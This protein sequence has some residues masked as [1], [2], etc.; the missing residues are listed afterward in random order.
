[1]RG[2]LP[3]SARTHRSAATASHRVTGGVAAVAG[4][5]LPHRRIAVSEHMLREWPLRFLLAARAAYRRLP[6]LTAAYRR[7]PPLNTLQIKSIQKLLE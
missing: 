6:P 4:R 2:T 1:M 5:S 3:N 7:L